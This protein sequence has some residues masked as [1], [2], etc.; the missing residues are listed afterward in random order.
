MVRGL[1]HIFKDSRLHKLENCYYRY[2]M[3][4]V[5]VILLRGA[6]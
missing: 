1:D 3:I 6:A 5:A 2:I 4:C